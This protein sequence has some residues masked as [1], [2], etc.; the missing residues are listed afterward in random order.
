M[1]VVDYAS[2][3][4]ALE[5]MDISTALNIKQKFE[6]P[7]FICQQHLPFTEMG[8]ICS[9]EEK[10]RVNLT[11]IMFCCLVHCIELA[12]KDALKSTLFD[13]VDNMLMCVYYIYNV[14]KIQV[15]LTRSALF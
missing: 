3:A 8:P 11:W 10:H 15:Y 5:K 6:I 2:I 1:S 7:Y 12:V 13:D 9:L 14:T 4:R